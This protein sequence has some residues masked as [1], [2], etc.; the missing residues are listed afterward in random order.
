M[1]AAKSSID[2]KLNEYKVAWTTFNT[3]L[4]TIV[5]VG[6]TSN[7]NGAIT[8]SEQTTRGE[9]K[10]DKKNSDTD[11]DFI[12]GTINAGGEAVVQSFDEVWIPGFE[13]FRDSIS[14]ICAQVVACMDE[15]AKDAIEASGG[16]TY[17][18]PDELLNWGG[19]SYSKP[20]QS[21][22]KRK[23]VKA[24]ADGTNGK[25]LPHK[26]KNA[27]R[28]EYGQP[29]LTVYPNGIAELTT[30]PVM[31]DLPKGTEVFNEEQ[32]HRIMNNKGEVVGEVHKNGIF[33]TLDKEIKLSDGSIIT[34]LSEDHPVF[35]LMKKWEA[36]QQKFND[37]MKIAA[38]N[39]IQNGMDYMTRN[40][41][42]V[43][44]NNNQ[45]YSVGDIHIHCSG[46]TSQDVAKEAVTA[47]EKQLF[48][49]SNR[50]NQ[51]ASI[52]R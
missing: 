10:T 8:N 36:N 21:E 26:E 38:M 16:K 24:F 31:S 1:T 29:E 47:I 51:R 25:G 50:A 28:S 14:D 39:S 52:T 3:D 9:N 6:G 35:D 4:G 49:M 42:N 7:Q 15:M 33:P 13:T 37:G 19:V 32:T 22:E 43:N 18:I 11:T 48:G 45:S 46:I 34:P 2:E 12:V 5:G 17:E 20:Y 44:T 23:K 40:I 30:E 41:S 27:L